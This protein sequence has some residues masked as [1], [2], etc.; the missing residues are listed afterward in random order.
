MELQGDC[1]VTAEDVRQFHSSGYLVKK[2]CLEITGL[3]RTASLVVDKVIE[4]ALQE[5]AHLAHA[6]AAENS[7]QV[8]LINGSRVVF[9]RNPVDNSLAIARINGVCGMA[10]VLQDIM[11]SHKMLNTFFDLLGV[12]DLEH[13]IA[14]LHPKR[15]GDGIGFPAHRDVDF[16]RSFDPAWE[17]IAGNGSYAICIIALDKMTEDNGGLYVDTTGFNGHET[18]GQKMLWVNAD[19]GDFIFLHPHLTHGSGPNISASD[20]RRALLSGFCVYGANHKPY[21]G[22]C[23]NMRY[24]RQKTPSQQRGPTS[25]SGDRA[26]EN[27]F[28]ESD[29]TSFLVIQPSPWKEELCAT[30]ANH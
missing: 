25:R 7:E 1:Y 9:K 4:S 19:P 12:D 28:S 2:N 10:P 18:D 6:H 20:N 5:A 26:S 8:V 27:C 30:D 29:D 21:P 16:R 24:T 15:A 22:A 14:Q 23:V 17:D 13:L 11:C 3:L